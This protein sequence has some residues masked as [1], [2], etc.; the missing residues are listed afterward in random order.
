[1]NSPAIGPAAGNPWAEN[2]NLIIKGL[3]MT[4]DMPTNREMT[5]NALYVRFLCAVLLFATA[6][7]A[8]AARAAEMGPMSDD[9]VIAHRLAPAEW[10]GT[11]P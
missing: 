6:F 9:S 1:M 3:V 5:M 7:M 10:C 2:L 11:R 8:T 4:G